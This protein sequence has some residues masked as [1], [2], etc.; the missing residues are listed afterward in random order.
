[1]ASIAISDFNA[2]VTTL[3]LHKLTETTARQSSL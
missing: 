1:M 3:W 2:D